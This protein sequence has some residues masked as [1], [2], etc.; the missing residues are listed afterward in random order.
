MNSNVD[1]N[2]D[3]LEIDI[4]RLIQ[5]VFSKI[6]L[7]VLFGIVFGLSAFLVSKFVMVPKYQA[8]IT[9][10]VSNNATVTSDGFDFNDVN[11]SITLVPTYIELMNSHNILSDVAEE[12]KDLGYS[13]DDIAD[14]I[15]VST[16]EETQI[17]SLTVTNPSA[18]HANIIANAIANIVPNKVVELM[19]GSAVRVIDESEIPEAPSSPSTKKNTLLGF[20]LGIII[21]IILAVLMELTDNSVKGESDLNSICPDLPILGIIPAFTKTEDTVSEY[22]QKEVK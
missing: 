5:A 7:I 14:M 15:S 3:A 1:I 16:V 8:N 10:Y 9:M 22:K 2:D 19:E 17:I 20:M 11:A 12:T 13:V 18:E 21:G 6:K 4:S